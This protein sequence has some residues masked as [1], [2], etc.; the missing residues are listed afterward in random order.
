MR[1]C[2]LLTRGMFA[3]AILTAYICPLHNYSRIM[4]FSVLKGWNDFRACVK[5]QCKSKQHQSVQR[6]KIQFWHKSKQ[7]YLQKNHRKWTRV[8]HFCY[9]LL[10]H[11]SLRV[12]RLLVDWSWRKNMYSKPLSRDASY[13]I[14]LAGFRRFFGFWGVIGHRNR[15][16]VPPMIFVTPLSILGIISYGD[17]FAKKVCGTALH[18]TMLSDTTYIYIYSITFPWKYVKGQMNRYAIVCYSML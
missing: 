13:M 12:R 6:W 4:W 10:S 5:S 8:H 2:C 9:L 16:N 18:C 17:G 1:I 15:H 7:V 11:G 3:F 14:V